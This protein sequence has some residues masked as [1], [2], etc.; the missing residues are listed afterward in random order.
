MKIAIS[1]RSDTDQHGAPRSVLEN[2]YEKYFQNYGLLIPVPNNVKNVE[3]YLTSLQIEGIIIA[4]G[5][6]VNPALYGE[7]QIWVR[8]IN[9]FFTKACEYFTPRL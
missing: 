3:E 5:N 6:D 9:I 4:G 2:A 7:K 8:P 1:M